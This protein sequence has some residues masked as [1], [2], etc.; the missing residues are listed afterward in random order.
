MKHKTW[1]YSP[2]KQKVQIPEKILCEISLACNLF[3]EKNYKPRFVQAFNPKNKKTRQ[4]VDVYWKQYRHFIHFKAVFH[5]LRP[6]IRE[7]TYEFPIARLE[8]SG[9]KLFHLAYFRHTGEWWTITFDNGISLDECFEMMSD[10][11]HF[12]SVFLSF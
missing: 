3:L 5:D 12:T 7:E 8:Y 2:A 4:C 9:D 11:P 6:N 1:I 10:M